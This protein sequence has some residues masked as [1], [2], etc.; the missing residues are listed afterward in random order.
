MRIRTFLERVILISIILTAFTLAP[1]SIQLCS[2][3]AQASPQSNTLYFPVIKIDE[4]WRTGISL[5]NSGTGEA[6]VTITTY[7]KFGNSISTVG[8]AKALRPGETIVISSTALPFGTASV[9]VETDG[10]LI[11]NANFVSSDGK[12]EESV[13]AI[14]SVAGQLIFPLLTSKDFLNKKITVLNPNN[15][16]ALI[17][18]IALDA[19]GAELAYK[20]QSIMPM[21]SFTFAVADTFCGCIA[22]KLSVVKVV[23]NNNSAGLQLVDLP[24]GDIVCLPGLNTTSKEW[25]FPIQGEAG[26]YELWSKIGIFNPGNSPAFVAFEAFGADKQSLGSLGNFILQPNTLQFLSTVNIKGSIPSDATTIRSASDMPV[27]GFEVIGMKSGKGIAAHVGITEEDKTVAG[28]QLKAN[29]DGNA[30]NANQIILGNGNIEAK[31]ANK[32][33][34]TTAMTLSSSIYPNLKDPSYQCPTNPYTCAGYGGQCTAFAWGRTREVMG[35]EL[36]VRHSPNTWINDAKLPVDNQPRNNSIAVWQGHVAYVETVVVDS[37][38]INEANVKTHNGSTYG[39]GYDGKPKTLTATA[40]KNRGA[41][42]G[43]FLGYIHLEN[44]RDT[45]APLVNSFTASASSIKLGSALTFHYTVTDS[46]GFGLKQVELWRGV[47]G[48]GLTNI[49]TKPISGNSNSGTFTDK[50]ASAATYSYGIHVVDNANNVGNE[51]GPKTVVI[52]GP[53]QGVSVNPGS[54]TWTSTPQ[55]IN[56]SCSD[57]TKIYYT[58]TATTNGTTPDPATP[59]TASASIGSSGSVQLYGSAG[60]LKTIKVRFRGYNGSTWGTTSSS[61]LYKIDLRDTAKPVVTSFSV[62]PASMKVGSTATISYAVTDN[63]GFGL[64][65]VELWRGVNGGG[66]TNIHTKPI[67]GNS[68]SGTF[69]DTPASAGIYSY[70]THVLDNAN[71]VGNENGAKTVTVTDNTPP[72]LR[73]DGSTSSTKQQSNGTFKIT[74][75]NLTP[76]SSVSR[77]LLFNGSTSDIGAMT[78]DGSG[79]LPSWSF[80]PTCGTAVGTYKVW[81][82]DP[83]KGNSNT[84]TEIVTANP[85]CSA[86]PVLTIDGST[87]STKQQ[88]GTFVTTCTGLTPN[89]EITRYMNLPDQS[90]V[91][92]TPILYAD[93]S[94]QRSWSYTSNCT[95]GT[96]TY[97]I[98]VKDTSSGRSSNGVNEIV[99]PSANCTDYEGFIDAADCS[100]IRG[101]AWDKNQPNSSINAD[102]YDGNTK[103]ATVGAN[104]FRQDL[105]N[106]GKGNG[107]HGFT[108]NTPS[109]LKDGSAHNVH[110][111]YAGTSIELSGSPKADPCSGHASVSYGPWLSSY[112]VTRGQ[113]F[114]ITIKLK[115][116]SGHPKTF[117]HVRVRVTDPTGGW[118]DFASFDSV[119]IPANGTVQTHHTV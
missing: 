19:N 82:V 77:K 37:V 90:Q 54:G 84:V 60:N 18:I 55:Y 119:T 85:S 51:N 3:E 10:D 42:I 76:N 99:T 83:V 30:L 23:P 86:N 57:A 89:A 45:T 105:V 73:I 17:D 39:G 81:I 107:Y 1:P 58:I 71:N 4:G 103:L 112:P 104:Q 72:V 44:L 9:K 26:G 101:W 102:I 96:G 16:T 67:S 64:K 8:S 74:C 36:A 118:F 63:G 20:N 95:T 29:A 97:Y 43:K 80:S 2:A 116:R 25:T 87:T 111:K 15:S 94:G 48:G 32:E 108:Y 41:L 33:I 12:K 7:D 66:L 6:I 88:G 59:T 106:A 91:I 14:K 21:E 46:G 52:T 115:E 35:I 24:D 98:W 28:I 31:N 100:S 69:T 40:M 13:P 109:S 22:D 34:T 27:S 56:V 53:P 92:L 110:V 68:N 11:G 38:T 47:N 70:G 114:T 79:N 117:E 65:Q 50:P 78:A 62:N 93:A 75:S 49:N 113:N 5:T 61:Y